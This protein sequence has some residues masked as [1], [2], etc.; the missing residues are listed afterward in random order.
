MYFNYSA[1]AN[2]GT[3]LPSVVCWIT[4]A[5]LYD[6]SKIK[7]AVSAARFWAARK[8]IIAF[9][10]FTAFWLLTGISITF[11]FVYLSNQTTTRSTE[12]LKESDQYQSAILQVD[13]TQKLV[14][15]LVQ[16]S[17]ESQRASK[18]A[19]M[20]QIDLKIE[21][22][23]NT[24]V[25]NYAG[26]LAGTFGA[27]NR[28]GK[29]QSKYNIYCTKVRLLESERFQITTWLAKNDSYQSTAAALRLKKQALDKVSTGDTDNK[30]GQL[31]PF[32]TF[33]SLLS[34][35]YIAA[36]SVSMFF[37]SVFSE[38]LASLMFV[39]YSNTF[40]S[41]SI[42]SSSNIFSS[43]QTTLA[44]SIKK[45]SDETATNTPDAAAND[46]IPF[47]NVRFDKDKIV[48]SG[49]SKTFSI[50]D[51]QYASLT[52]VITLGI[53]PPTLH[54]LRKKYGLNAKLIST[55]QTHWLKSGLIVAYQ[56]GNLTSYKLATKQET[57]AISG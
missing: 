22:Y 19:R 28:C 1:V 38:L 23:N 26:R 57:V 43:I 34:I 14:D 48:T 8:F 29:R 39:S 7:L 9:F 24:E 15:G 47:D 18:T 45:R 4:L 16:F 2:W 33:S 6:L 3:S 13:S 36:L 55:L 30:E 44:N 52:K 11:G 21:E 5:L 12:T 25:Y 49:H 42:K 27:M 41:A 32:S 54:S 56:R 35:N 20:E 40:S 51:T 50:T 37:L 17:S 53:C 31:E 46:I 10:Q